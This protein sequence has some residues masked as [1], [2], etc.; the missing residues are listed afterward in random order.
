MERTHAAFVLS[1][2]RSSS[3]NACSTL[4]ETLCPL[5]TFET[6]VVLTPARIAAAVAIPRLSAKY[7]RNASRRRAPIG[8]SLKSAYRCVELMVD[9]RIRI[10]HL[11]GSCQDVNRTQIG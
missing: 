10:V 11:T 1:H 2:W 5:R 4:A 3:S 6:I 9:S 7:L 8:R